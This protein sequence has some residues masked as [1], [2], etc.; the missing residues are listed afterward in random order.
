MACGLTLALLASA[1]CGG[2]K[3]AKSDPSQVGMVQSDPD[4]DLNA[5]GLRYSFFVDENVQGNRADLRIAQMS[6]GRM[7]DVY[8]LMGDQASPTEVLMQENFVIGSGIES[9]L[10]KYD[11]R[12]NPVTGQESLLIKRNVNLNTA[13]AEHGN[14]Y[15]E[16]FSILRQVGTSLTPIFDNTQGAAGFYTMV[17]R[18]AT[19]VLTFDDLLRASTISSETVRVMSG[20]P[21][22]VPFLGRILA[23][24]NHGDLADRDGDLVK[25]FYTTRVLIDTTIN[26]I[27]SFLSNP[28]L[29]VNTNGL[30]GSIGVNQANIKIRIATQEVAAVGQEAVLRNLSGHAL[31]L[32]GNGS[33]DTSSQT[34]DIVRAVRAGG[35]SALTNDPYNGYLRDEEAPKLLGTQSV[36]IFG[37]G[38][39][40]TRDASDPTLRTFILPQ[41][42]FTSAF[43]AQTPSIGDVIKQTSLF[44]EVIEAPLAHVQ[45]TLE[46]VRVR[47]LAYPPEWDDA[48]PNDPTSQ[49]IS[50]GAGAAQFISPYDVATDLGQEV[51]Y[52][53]ITPTPLQFPSTPG[54]GV[55]PTA[56][57]GVRF[58]E[59][60][61]PT[62]ISAFDTLTVTRKVEPENNNDY[63]V[64]SIAL[65]LDLR[66]YAFVPSLPLAHSFAT[67]ERYYVS[68]GFASSNARPTDLAGNALS[69]QLSGIELLLN[70]ST[71]TVATS[72]RVSRFTAPDEE[73][74]ENPGAA[75]AGGYPEYYGQHTYN[76]AR[77]VIRPRPVIRYDGVVDRNHPVTNLWT[78]WGNNLLQPPI[79]EP[80]NRLGSRLQTVWRN[81]DMDF[82]LGDNTNF[83]IDVEGLAWAPLGGQVISDYYGEFEI[84]LAHCT[85]VPD[86]YWIPPPFD[87][88]G[89]PASGL[90]NLFQNNL[91]DGATDP[92]SVVHPKFR[93]YSVNPGEKYNAESGTVL[94]PFPLNRDIPANEYRY[95]TWRDTSLL[96]RAGGD[97]SNPGQNG[98]GVN[99][100]QYYAAIGFPMPN[101]VA[102]DFVGFDAGPYRKFQPA[103][104]VQTIGLPLLMDFKAYPDDQAIGLNS[105][106]IGLGGQRD[107][108][109]VFRAYSAGGQNANQEIVRIDPDLETQANGG[110]N[111]QGTPAGAAVPG[112][113]TKVYLG[114]IN[115]V[116]RVSRSF[117]V[118]FPV[119]AANG[120]TPMI[121]VAFDTPIVEP[122]S[123]NQPVGTSVTLAF[124][125]ASTLP[126]PSGSDNR[127]EVMENATLIDSYGDFYYN[128]GNGPVPNWPPEYPERHLSEEANIGI[129]FLDNQGDWYEDISEIDTAQYFQVRITFQSNAESGQSPELSALA[130]AWG[131]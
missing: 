62:S 111:P 127:S 69:T 11:L 38:G 18:N 129:G 116:V 122:S 67:E 55:L 25:E 24:R 29:P 98:S 26:E 125:G 61:D 45:G 102:A 81:V 77:Q 30:P 41:V 60:M 113:D 54:A 32:I 93:G 7:V 112:L 13:T 1:G 100:H 17:P 48:T 28:P 65:S 85:K 114:A 108:A 22:V 52:L 36:R 74:N 59:P 57:F 118:W 53:Q 47:L 124:R 101:F 51:C 63:V 14:E 15:E 115:F 72:G 104:D 92:L 84:A 44:A 90:L 39:L 19:I 16:Y 117:S 91:L 94:M 4:S 66:S 120:S 31:A 27:E 5:A 99:I 80:L 49:W 83:N 86:E 78:A 9:N 33:T 42:V 10:T 95:Y 123:G 96:E 8:A 89:A 56:N 130:V 34:R 128:D 2:G 105:F 50:T 109:P 6:W 64:G 76:I 131:T 75:V 88:P 43:C 37:N 73:E 82:E 126:S 107:P 23:D 71:T 87:I 12:R 46:N 21:A 70:A 106:D 121:G 35:N 3:T 110:F 40:L 119:V 79:Q 20:I 103:G 58:S 68:L 97:G